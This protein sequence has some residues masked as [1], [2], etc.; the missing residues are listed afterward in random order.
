M[1]EFDDLHAKNS[2][3]CP[4][5][6]KLLDYLRAKIA[7]KIHGDCFAYDVDVCSAP[8]YKQGRL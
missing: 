2:S 3:S 5:D 4:G 6:E 8:P 7:G 1:A